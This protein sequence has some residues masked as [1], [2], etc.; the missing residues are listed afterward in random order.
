MRATLQISVTRVAQE[1]RISVA[2]AHRIRT[3]D[4]SLFPYKIQVHQAL[5]QVA[6][7]KS[8]NFATEFGAYIDT[9]PSVLSLIWFSDEAHFWLEGYVNKHNCCIWVGSNPG[10][11]LTKNL[12]PKKITIWAALRTQGPISPIFVEKNVDGRGNQKIL[13]KDA[14]LQFMAMKNFLKLWFQQ[15]GAKA[16]T[17]DL[18]LDLVET[19]FKKCVIS[20]CFPL[21]KR[22][23][24]ARRRTAPI[25]VL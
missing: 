6:V 22:G 21:K 3:T 18:T 4:I 2:S 13:K 15:D 17:V 25:S 24:G 19:Y 10:V 11:F 14:F 16:H 12:H 20:N 1:I 5:S 23:A 7:G 9:H 8:L